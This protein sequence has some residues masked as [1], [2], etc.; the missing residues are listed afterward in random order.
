MKI[1]YDFAM[2]LVGI[3]YV[4]GN[5]SPLS[6]DCSGLIF[7]LLNSIG[8]APKEDMNADGLY[9]FFLDN[10]DIGS[11][12]LGSLCFFGSKD[13][14]RHVGFAL[15]D[16]RMLEAMGGNEWVVTEEKAKAVGA[17]VTI[18]MINRRKDLVACITPRYALCGWT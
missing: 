10:G 15:D 8:M 11:P 5:Q 16:R 14:I 3:P 6:T 4:Y 17:C 1:L 18:S 12:R 2:S 7:I 9:R 13:R